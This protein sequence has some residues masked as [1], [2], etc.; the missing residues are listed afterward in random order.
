[1]NFKKFNEALR[2]SVNAAL[3][4]RYA[5]QDGRFNLAA[6]ALTVSVSKFPLHGV[7]TGGVSELWWNVSFKCRI[8]VS[9]NICAI[10]SSS[11]Y[12]DSEK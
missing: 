6:A 1:M 9:P 4:L 8:K 11:T 12:E 3:Q 7:L 5:A 10:P 2:Q